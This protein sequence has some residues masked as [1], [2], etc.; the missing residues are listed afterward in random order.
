MNLS[1]IFKSVKTVEITKEQVL[2]AQEQNGFSM[3]DLMDLFYKEENPIIVKAQEPTLVIFDNVDYNQRYVE[4]LFGNILESKVEDL[5][6][7][8]EVAKFKGI[9]SNYN[10]VLCYGGYARLAVF[11]PGK[12]SECQEM[13]NSEIENEV[14]PGIIGLIPT[15][16]EAVMCREAIAPISEH[17][18]FQ[19]ASY[20]D[21]VINKQ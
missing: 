3:K 2:K 15:T 1:D 16:K 20:M 12:I 7:E 10:L 6:D 8:K 18:V 5:N 14:H 21:A 17:D 4:D 9:L 19:M 13:N 11:N